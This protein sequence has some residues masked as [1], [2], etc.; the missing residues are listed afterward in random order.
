M[1]SQEYSQYNQS[2][3]Q[4]IIKKEEKKKNS[5]EDLKLLNKKC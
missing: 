5:M 4:G 3:P 2:L 1:S